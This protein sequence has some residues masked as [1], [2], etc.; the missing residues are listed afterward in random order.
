MVN[1]CIKFCL[2]VWTC[3]QCKPVIVQISLPA[4]EWKK[5]QQ[6]L[7]EDKEGWV[8]RKETKF[9]KSVRRCNIWGTRNDTEPLNRK[10]ADQLKYRP[11]FLP[12][13]V[14]LKPPATEN[15]AQKGNWGGSAFMAEVCLKQNH[16]GRGSI[17]IEVSWQGTVHSAVTFCLRLA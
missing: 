3:H 2:V 12:P 14:Q 17:R 4:G 15:V 6:D 13:N 1:R 9:L 10:S 5:Q 7:T 8:S 11:R 16:S